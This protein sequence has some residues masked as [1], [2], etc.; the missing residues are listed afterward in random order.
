MQEVLT[1]EQMAQADLA[2]IALGVPGTELMENAGCAVAGH[3]RSMCAPG[4]NVLVVCGPGNNG[5]DGF[6]VARHLA[7]SGYKVHV[8]LAGEKSA[9]TGDA[10]FM[11][12]QWSG[13]VHGPDAHLPERLDLIIDAM[14][15]AGLSRPIEAEAGRLVDLMHR[16]DCRVLAVDMPSGV[17]GSTGLIEG[18]AV[19]ADAT[20]TFF[21][22]K[23]GHLL[24]PGRAL[25]GEIFLVD[26]GIPEQ[27][28]GELGEMALR[29][30]PA[31]WLDAWPKLKA[32]GHKFDRGHVLVASGGVAK[33]GA[34]RLAARGALRMA[35]IKFVPCGFEFRPGVQPQRRD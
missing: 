30:H 35:A 5:G 18:P 20:V 24:L 14:F 8:V 28:L 22:L 15:G 19:R 4:S 31:L 12:E 6:V 11:L 33:S 9:V 10:R 34:A 2:A 25:C 32:A 29:N 23:P 13:P 21:R 16:A 7:A 3:A 1:N 27:V 17:N 26:I